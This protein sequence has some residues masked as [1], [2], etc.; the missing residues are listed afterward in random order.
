METW[1]DIIGYEGSYQVSNKGRVKSLKRYVKHSKGGKQIL[2]ERILKGRSG[3]KNK[4]ITVS[5]VKDA[6]GKSYSIHSLVSEAFMGYKKPKG[7]VVDHINKDLK[8]NNIEN[9]RYCTQRENLNNRS[10]VSNT[11][12][13]GVSINPPNYKKRYRARIRIN[14]K[15]KELGSFETAKQAGQAYIKEKNKIENE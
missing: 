8:N 10:L 11:G 4:Y 7:F 13:V 5:L 15:M 12:Y 1:E 6:K 3:N 9:L 14:E 2:N